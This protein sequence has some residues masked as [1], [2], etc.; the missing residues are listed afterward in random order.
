MERN[1]DAAFGEFVEQHFVD[2]AELELVVGID[3]HR[4]FFVQFGARVRTPKSKRL[5]ISLFA[6]S[7]ALRISTQFS[8]ETVSNEGIAGPR[9]YKTLKC[10]GSRQRIS[11]S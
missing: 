5:V 9:S 3:R 4:L 11:R 1:V 10:K 7:S 6:W 2:L 8:S